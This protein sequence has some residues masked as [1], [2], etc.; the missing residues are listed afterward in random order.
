MDIKGKRIFNYRPVC[1]A[2]LAMML[3][4]IVGEAI[5]G[6]RLSF[7]SIPVCIFSAAIIVV[8]VFRKSRRFLYL[9]LFALIGSLGIIVC[10]AVYAGAATGPFT[11]VMTARVC[12]EIVAVEPGTYKFYV[13]DISVDGESTLKYSAVVYAYNMSEEPDYNA[14]DAVLIVGNLKQFEADK[15]GSTFASVFSNGTAYSIVGYNVSKT[16]EGTPDL[17]LAIEMKIKSMLFLN[18]DESGAEIAQGLLLGDKFGMDKD[19]KESVNNTGLSH[20]LAVSGLHISALSAG[21]YFLLK[22]LKVKPLP[23]FIIVTAALLVYALMCSFTA[24]VLRALIM[25]VVFHLS[26]MLGKKHDSLTALGLSAIII[27]L[28][29]PTALFEAGFLMSFSSVLGIITFGRSFDR[30][31][32]KIVDKISPK[33]RFGRRIAGL[34]ATALSANILLYPIVAYYYGSFPVFFL[35]SS[36]I[37]LP[38]MTAVYIILLA[39]MLIGLITTLGGVMWIMRMLFIPFRVYVAVVGGLPISSFPVTIL[40]VAGIVTYML[41]AVFCSRYVFIDGRSKVKGGMCMASV[42]LLLSAAIALL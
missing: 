13:K 17:L 41:I 34:I 6:E 26:S 28:F 22:K 32:Q 33:R 4:I 23:S 7:I 19:F 11:G 24:S 29:R 38:Y 21:L 10:S 27:L 30:I 12:S 20:I 14:G 39:L 36:V 1:F 3:G 18:I 37:M 42:G 15:F 40:G 8:A 9:P 25:S 35:L 16:A 2:A 31:G 5:R